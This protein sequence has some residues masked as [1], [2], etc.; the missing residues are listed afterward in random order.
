MKE[1]CWFV[2]LHDLT[3]GHDVIVHGFGRRGTK[4][5]DDFRKHYL[6]RHPGHVVAAAAVEVRPDYTSP[7]WR[8]DPN[9][10]GDDFLGRVGRSLDAFGKA[11]ASLWLDDPRCACACGCPTILVTG[12]SGPRTVCRHCQQGFCGE[13]LKARSV[14]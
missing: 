4:M 12:P 11:F 2:T 6:G 9:Y 14:A 1:R 5:I 3:L 13:R 10:C 8:D 7:T